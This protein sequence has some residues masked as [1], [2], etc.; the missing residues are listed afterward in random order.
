MSTSYTGWV[1]GCCHEQSLSVI[2]WL[3]SSSSVA[4]SGY[5]ECDSSDCET[6]LSED[7]EVD[8]SGLG[9]S[10]PKKARKEKR[11]TAKGSGRFRKVGIC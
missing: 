5:D 10:Q 4:A 8:I 9:P 6:S 11:P 1:R 7:V 2:S 3:S